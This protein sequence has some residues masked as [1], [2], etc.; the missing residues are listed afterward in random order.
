MLQGEAG[1]GLGCQ[2]PALALLWGAVEAARRRTGM[3]IMV[4]GSTG[5][6]GSKKGQVV[7]ES[8]MHTR[9][10]SGSGRGCPGAQRARGK[11]LAG[12]PGRGNEVLCAV[13]CG[14]NAVKTAGLG[15][16]GKQIQK[17]KA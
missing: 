11:E 15:E 7:L 6:R 1:R 4:K 14:A 2:A 9:R 8:E 17:T 10:G 5:T 13:V 16:R 12:W 3:K